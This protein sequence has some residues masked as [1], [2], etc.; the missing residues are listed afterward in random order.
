M[1]ER[2]LASP[3]L[4][5]GTAVTPGEAWG[6]AVLR[7]RPGAYSAVAAA[8]GIPPSTEACRA[9]VGDTVAALWLGPDERLLLR[10]PSAPAPELPDGVV[11]SLVDV[12]HR[13]VAITIAG[14]RAEEI[15]AS[16]CPLDLALSAF[17]MG[18]CTRTLFHKAEVVLWRTA[19]ERFHL[20]VWRSFARYVEA[21]LIEADREG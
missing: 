3:L 21:L 5:G 20:E 17:P 2:E 1:L 12:S 13:Q 15:L 19:P 6:R 11:G 9:S 4:G 14:P 7:C 10:S 18:A 16:G 8:L